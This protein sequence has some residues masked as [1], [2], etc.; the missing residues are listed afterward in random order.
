[1]RN[2]RSWIIGSY[3]RV[4]RVIKKETA[5]EIVIELDCGTCSN[6]KLNIDYEKESVSR[7]CVIHKKE[8]Q[9]EDMCGE[10]TPKDVSLDKDKI[11][12]I[13]NFQSGELYCDNRE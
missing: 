5:K 6:C 11:C 3:W 10:H 2:Y 7:Y 9:R 12:N 8:V 4:N 1:M 13:H